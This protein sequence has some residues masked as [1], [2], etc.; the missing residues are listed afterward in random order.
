[1]L[2]SFVSAEK[3]ISA[4]CMP[5]VQ[6]EKYNMIYAL[7]LNCIFGGSVH[8]AVFVTVFFPRWQCG[9]DISKNFPNYWFHIKSCYYFD[10]AMIKLC[11]FMIRTH[12][13]VF[14]C[15]EFKRTGNTT[16]AIAATAAAAV[17]R[18]FG[19]ISDTEW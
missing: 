11:T 17:T 15:L 9:V 12:K 6:K 1:M 3:F 10:N 16:T 2:Y 14:P 7:S 13:F 19:K 8:G 4:P 18:L 5:N